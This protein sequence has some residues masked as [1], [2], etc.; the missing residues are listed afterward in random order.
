[1]SQEALR[2]PCSSGILNRQPFYQE[3]HMQAFRAH[4]W[5]A[6]WSLQRKFPTVYRE[7]GQRRNPGR[8]YWVWIIFVN[9]LFSR[10]RELNF[11]SSQLSL[12]V[13]CGGHVAIFTSLFFKGKSSLVVCPTTRQKVFFGV[14]CPLQVVSLLYL[15]LT[16]L[17]KSVYLWISC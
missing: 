15:W 4:L 8:W 16:F 14:A 10:E 12:F 11:F 5:T 6:I 3:G 13:G 2:G 7:N 1:M 9:V 17:L